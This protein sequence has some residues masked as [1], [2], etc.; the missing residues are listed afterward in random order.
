[1]KEFTNDDS[2]NPEATY[3]ATQKLSIPKLHNQAASTLANEI[4]MHLLRMQ[5]E[6]KVSDIPLVLRGGMHAAFKDN[7]NDSYRVP[8][9]PDYVIDYKNTLIAIEMD[10]GNQRGTANAEKVKQY[11]NWL[12]NHPLATH[13]R[14]LIIFAVMDESIAPVIVKDRT[15]RVVTLR[16]R[17]GIQHVEWM[18]DSR[19]GVYCALSIFSKELIGNLIQ[20]ISMSNRSERSFFVSQWFGYLAGCVK[21]GS[22]FLETVNKDEYKPF[23]QKWDEQWEAD[24]YMS[25][26]ENEKRPK[27]FFVLYVD[28]GSSIDYRR[29]TAN[30]RRVK[31]INESDLT[32]LTINLLLVYSSEV[33]RRFDSIGNLKQLDIPVYSTSSEIFNEMYQRGEQVEYIQDLPLQLLSRHG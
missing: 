5:K 4:Y 19:I 2:I 3:A 33:E 25:L 9:Q 21:S 29:I 15:R 31:T 23:S 12:N 13:K 26:K 28:T 6:N 32:N 22:M 24:E 18:N 10:T 7:R 20:G 30:I 17:T 1:M 11:R 27:H 16:E 14:L 8:V